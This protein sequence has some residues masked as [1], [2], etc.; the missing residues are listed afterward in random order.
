MSKLNQG[1]MRRFLPLFAMLLSPA[2]V[3]CGAK[4]QPNLSLTAPVPESLREKCPRAKADFVSVGD[5][6]VFAIKEDADISICEAKKD[7]AVAILDAYNKAAAEVAQQL[8]P[9]HWW[10]W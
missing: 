1:R 8:K 6:G 2:F 10:P 3:S 5:L 4:P 9:R 7:A